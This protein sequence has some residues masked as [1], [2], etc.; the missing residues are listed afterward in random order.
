MQVK[1]LVGRIFGLVSIVVALGI[2]VS[3]ETANDAVATANITNLI[4]MEIMA[5][6]GA[7]LIIF[8][9]LTS[10]GL[11][12]SGQI[13]DADSKDV[14]AIVGEVVL[15]VLGLTFMTN[16]ITYANNL[17]G[18]DTTDFSALLYG[19]I[20]LVV[21]LA[22]VAMAARPAYS[23]FKGKISNRRAKG[24]GMSGY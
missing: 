14:I 10:G 16:I 15:A 8:S 18:A 3:I 11:F 17:I 4:G 19:L 24:S 20:P 13:K 6:F 22:I 21:Y 7:P 12:A 23:F 2:G 9:L 1:S 5:S